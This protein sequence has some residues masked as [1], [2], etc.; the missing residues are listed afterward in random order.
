MAQGMAGGMGPQGRRYTGPYRCHKAVIVI[1]GPTE[2]MR[3]NPST[4]QN[5][6][7]IHP[8]DVLLTATQENW[9]LVLTYTLI[10]QVNLGNKKPAMDVL[11]ES[12]PHKAHAS[13][14]RN[15]SQSKI[16]TL[17]SALS[18]TPWGSYQDL[19][20]HTALR[21]QAAPGLEV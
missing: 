9:P 1:Q 15:R 8:L 6:Q 5:R 12:G 21:V 3:V 18:P 16:P 2:A 14:S 10:S 13:S 20:M 4:T 17:L 11:Q 7:Y 19:R